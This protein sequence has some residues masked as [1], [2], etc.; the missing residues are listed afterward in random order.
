M[1]AFIG[2][3]DGNLEIGKKDGVAFDRIDIGARLPR[4]VPGEG[5]HVQQHLFRADIHDL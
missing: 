4:D 2:S 1:G 5:R 3:D